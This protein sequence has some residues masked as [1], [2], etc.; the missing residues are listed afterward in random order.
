[1]AQRHRAFRLHYNKLETKAYP[2]QILIW[3]EIVNDTV[4]NTPVTMTF[5]PLCNTV[6]AFNRTLNDAI[7]DFGTTGNLRYR[8]LVMYDRQTRPGGNRPQARQLWEI[9][10]DVIDGVFHR[11]GTAFAL[12]APTIAMSKDIGAA[13]VSLS[14]K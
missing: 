7:L 9:I 2:L 6:I 14:S 5:C 10:N 3:H 11:F 1:M 4:G 8:D 12:D 13:A